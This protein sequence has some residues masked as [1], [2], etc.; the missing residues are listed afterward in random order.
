MQRPSSQ[1]RSTQLAGQNLAKK[2]RY[3]F[4]QI[5]VHGQ[6]TDEDRRPE[7]NPTDA[8]KPWKQNNN[9]KMPTRTAVPEGSN[10]CKREASS[11]NLCTSQASR[12]TCAVTKVDSLLHATSLAC[13]D[14]DCTRSRRAILYSTHTGA[15]FGENARI[16]FRKLFH[17]NEDISRS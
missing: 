15:N 7:E 11:S 3:A 16:I 14:G 4:G 9:E 6:I 13:R 8:R 1:H 2:T 5:S 12:V 17:K 10:G